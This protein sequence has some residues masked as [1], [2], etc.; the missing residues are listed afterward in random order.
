MNEKIEKLVD[1]V[2]NNIV[3]S[4]SPLA[5]KYGDYNSYLHDDNQSVNVKAKISINKER[6]KAEIDHSKEFY[7]LISNEFGDI[8][9]KDS[10]LN[11][12]DRKELIQAAHNQYEKIMNERDK[13]LNAFIAETGMSP[14]QCIMVEEKDHING[15]TK[16]SFKLKDKNVGIKNE[17]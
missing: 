12:I 13:F 2:L 10:L 16:I 7:N 9:K 14:S 5:K 3:L 15:N 6:T 17:M 1:L 4:I 11:I 8:V